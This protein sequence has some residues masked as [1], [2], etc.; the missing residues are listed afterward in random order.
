[1]EKNY[2]DMYEPLPDW[3]HEADPEKIKQNCADNKHV[4]FWA[5]DKVWCQR[6]QKNMTIK[7]WHLF[8]RKK[9]EIKI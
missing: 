5:G 4:P 8:W 6:C 2:D 9:Q 3:A 7:E 1:M